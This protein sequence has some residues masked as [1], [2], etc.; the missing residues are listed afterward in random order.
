[1][2]PR[3]DP[4]RSVHLPD[5]GLCWRSLL[6][7]D[8][9]KHTAKRAVCSADVGARRLSVV[10]RPAW[11]LRTLLDF[12]RDEV[13]GPVLIA[14]DA[15]IG[16]PAGYLVQ[17]PGWE[18]G[19]TFLEWLPKTRELPRFFDEAKRVE[20]LA[21]ERPFFAVPAGKGSRRAFEVA[22]RWPMRRPVEEAYGAKPVFITSGI[23]GTVGSASRELWRELREL[24]DEPDRRFRVWPFEG[25]PDLSSGQPGDVVLAEAYPR[26]SY[27]GALAAS[28]PTSPRAVA[29]TR[30]AARKAASREL[31][32]ADW[33]GRFEVR[34]PDHEEIV[35][36]EDR[37]DAVLTAAA[38]LRC[39]L[40]GR[41]LFDLSQVDPVAEGGI[42][43][44]G[45]L[46]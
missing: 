8:W 28:L 46:I 3:A 27:A 43:G 44:G 13:A 35:S 24:L 29:K 30:R 19:M 12:A 18:P 38:T 26:A 9:S 20:D 39:L 33:V 40:E 25:D 42:L 10:D 5:R 15:V 23:P 7:A 11:S 6:C 45:V 16:V 37:F 4:T 1:M 36:D 22:A 17:A 34:L 2:M 14:I 31:L 41:P 21:P 32:G